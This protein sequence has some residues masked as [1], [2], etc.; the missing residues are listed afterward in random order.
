MLIDITVPP[1]L[2]EPLPPPAWLVG[3]IVA[4][5]LFAAA[6][7]LAALPQQTTPVASV[8]DASVQ[9]SAAITD[10]AKSTPIPF[11]PI[12]LSLPLL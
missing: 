1:P 12:N 5:V 8:T 4:T 2:D 7:L 11:D 9:R 3:C 10:I 6:A